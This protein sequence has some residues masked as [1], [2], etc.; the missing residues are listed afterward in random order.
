MGDLDRKDRHLEWVIQLAEAAPAFW[1]NRSVELM[2]VWTRLRQRARG[3]EG[4]E[5]GNLQSALCDHGCSRRFGLGEGIS[6]RRGGRERRFSFEH[7]EGLTEWSFRGGV[8][9][10]LDSTVRRI[11]TGR[12]YFAALS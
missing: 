6:R 4:Q 11:N 10:A 3:I 12:L 8:L 2:S 7:A 9:L 5:K 1:G